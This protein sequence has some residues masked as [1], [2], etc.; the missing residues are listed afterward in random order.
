MDLAVAA[1][2]I[3]SAADRAF[4]PEIAVFG[5]VGLMGEVRAV[6]RAAER[7]REVE[8][9]GFGKAVLPARNA[10]GEFNLPVHAVTEVA[11]LLDLLC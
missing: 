8:A 6:S 11:G 10:T 7:V 9:L 5:E 3:S 1:A 2:L 4:P